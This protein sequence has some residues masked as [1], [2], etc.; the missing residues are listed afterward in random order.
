MNDGFYRGDLSTFQLR[1][2]YPNGNSS[3]KQRKEERTAF[4]FE[5]VHGNK[6]KDCTACSGYKYYCGGACGW[7]DGTG[8][9]RQR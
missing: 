2:F 7:C 1:A 8:K 9:E 4:Y 5:H 3:F 6:L